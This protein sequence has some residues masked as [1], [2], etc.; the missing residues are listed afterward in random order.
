MTTISKILR[1]RSD[2]QKRI[3]Q[4]TI[5]LCVCSFVLCVDLCM[6]SSLYLYV[7]LCVYLYVYVCLFSFCVFAYL[8]ISPSWLFVKPSIDRSVY[9]VYHFDRSNLAQSNQI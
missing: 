8:F 5:N 3:H 4:V 2:F 9:F 7:C 6:R 1:R